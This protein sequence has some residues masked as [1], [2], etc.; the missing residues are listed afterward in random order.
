MAESERRREKK[1][2]RLIEVV[3]QLLLDDASHFTSAD[4]YHTPVIAAGDEQRGNKVKKT[5]RIH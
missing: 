4:H 3:K 2:G 5:E 1:E